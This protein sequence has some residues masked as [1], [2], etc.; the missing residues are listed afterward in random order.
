MT[1]VW[2]VLIGGALLAAM[3]FVLKMPRAGW[4]IT[5][6][7]LLFGILG[8]RL[9]GHPGLAGSPTEALENAK[10]A[11]ATLLKERQQM[12]SSGA[13]YGRAGSWM[14][15]ADALT[16]Q[17]QFGA[18]A[19]ILHKATLENPQDADLWVAQ[20]NALIG[21]AGG[22]I[23]PAAKLAFTR[24]ATI[25]PDHRG[26]PFFIGLALAQGGRLAEARTIWADLL[27]RSPADA[28]YRNDLQARLG[29]IDAILAESAGAPVGA[30]APAA[31]AAPQP[32]PAPAAPGPR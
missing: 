20:G 4:E 5:A 25:A 21:H 23:T 18:A 1:W 31:A 2:I 22:A 30:G 17:G 13:A 29:Q 6:A 19:D 11:D 12:S 9:Q 10:L 24:A 26:P 8:Y 27:A 7:A 3:I 16:R 14:V 15:L 28:P 32:S